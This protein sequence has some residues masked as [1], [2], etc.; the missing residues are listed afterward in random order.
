[1]ILKDKKVNSDD[2]AKT[3]IEFKK[4]FWIYDYWIRALVKVLFSFSIKSN[5]INF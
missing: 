5:F 4:I 1:M 3:L 2:T